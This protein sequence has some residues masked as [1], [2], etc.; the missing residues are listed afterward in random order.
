MDN[1]VMKRKPLISF[2]QHRMCIMVQL[3][4]VRQR[5]I[6]FHGRALDPEDLDGGD[7][8]AEM[9]GVIVAVVP[10]GDEPL[11]EAFK[12]EHFLILVLSASNL[13]QVTPV[14]SNL[15]GR[16]SMTRVQ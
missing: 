1:M 14:T 12:L 10:G 11:E 7:W 8:A 2:I 4:Q 3:Q 16:S 9:V 15:V 6:S 13:L 5:S